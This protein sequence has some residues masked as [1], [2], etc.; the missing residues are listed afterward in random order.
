MLLLALGLAWLLAK[1]II[2]IYVSALF[3]AVLMPI[4]NHIMQIKVRG[5]RTSKAA[6]IFLIV[7]GMGLVVGIFLTVGLPPVVHDLN[8]FSAE[9]PTRIPKMMSR[10]NQLPIAN[11]LGVNEIAQRAEGAFTT[12]ASYLMT[13]LPNW[14]SHLFDILSAIFLCIYFM[15]EGDRAYRFALSLVPTLYRDR[16]GRTLERAD[17]KI[18]KWLVG[19]GLLMLILGI[20]STIV[21]AVLHVRYFLLL[22]FLMGLFNIIPIAGG[23]F[24][25]TLSAIVAAFDSWTK[26][27]GVVIFYLL[28]LNVENAY[29]TPR[30]M[31]SS[32]EL[33]GLTILIALLCGTAL[34]GVVGALVAV[35]TAAL[36]AVILEEYAVQ[37]D[38]V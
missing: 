15:L 36:I 35:P 11:R 8:Q 4:V 13:S 24:T 22:G 19:Q 9:L 37:K 25:I 10:V 18:G 14:L 30:I 31:G 16:L 20:S 1:E 23:V 26:L 38:A 3:A 27:A 2:L 32:V 29:L 21:F 33:S 28:Y 5:R 34:A 7:S 12:A 17:K 6:A